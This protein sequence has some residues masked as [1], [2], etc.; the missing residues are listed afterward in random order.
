MKAGIARALLT[1]VGALSTSEKMV[2]AC[3]SVERESKECWLKILPLCSF[4]RTRPAATELWR[5]GQS[6]HSAAP[7]TGYL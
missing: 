5:Q 7:V 1:I 3:E 6:D 2:P 4:G